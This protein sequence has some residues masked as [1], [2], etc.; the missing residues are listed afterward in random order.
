MKIKF[1]SLSLSL[2]L[3]LS[4]FRC[5]SDSETV[6]LAGGLD[7]GGPQIFQPNHLTLTYKIMYSHFGVRGVGWVTYGSLEANEKGKGM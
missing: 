4:L 7:S 1:K 5:K 6:H 3:P 2:S